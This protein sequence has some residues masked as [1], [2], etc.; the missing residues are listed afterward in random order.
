M[1]NGTMTNFMNWAANLVAVIHI[2]YFLF[3]LGGLIAVLIVPLATVHLCVLS[4]G[5][6]RIF[7]PPVK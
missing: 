3:V 4:A 7:G 5:M 6:A 1:V 2:G